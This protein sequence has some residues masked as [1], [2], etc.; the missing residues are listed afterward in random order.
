MIM[1]G[2][3]DKQGCGADCPKE[4]VFEKMTHEIIKS[5]KSTFRC[6]AIEKFILLRY[7][8]CLM[9]RLSLFFRSQAHLTI[10]FNC[11]IPVTP[12]PPLLQ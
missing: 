10:C 2:D 4:G 3:L 6:G 1:F 7:H 9:K 5:G 11:K 12:F 8:N